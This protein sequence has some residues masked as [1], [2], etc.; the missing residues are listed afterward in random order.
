[1][2]LN[3]EM[4][5]RCDRGM[6]TAYVHRDTEALHEKMQLIRSE[7]DFFLDATPG[8]KECGFGELASVLGV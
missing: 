3:Q 4:N 6:L 2:I 1:M 8:T 7:V 5:N